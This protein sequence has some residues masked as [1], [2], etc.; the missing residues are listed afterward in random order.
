M[1]TGV[2]LKGQSGQLTF[3]EAGS[4]EYACALHPAMKGRIEVSE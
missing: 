3:D 2:L 1:K 4:Y